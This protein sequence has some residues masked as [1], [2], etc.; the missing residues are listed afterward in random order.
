M[1][2]YNCAR[3]NYHWLVVVQNVPI[4]KSPRFF[5]KAIQICI[6]IYDNK[7]QAIHKSEKHDC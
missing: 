2:I 1:N 5:E 3:Q 7:R 6:S 4:E